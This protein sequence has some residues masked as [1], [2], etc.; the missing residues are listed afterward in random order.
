MILQ[1]ELG[2]TVNENLI[3]VHRFVICLAVL[4]VVNNWERRA[5]K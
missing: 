2:R 1:D 4:P 3:I 5:G